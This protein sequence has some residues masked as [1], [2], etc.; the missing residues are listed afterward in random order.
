MKSYFITATGTG[1]GK[2]LIT[3]ALC[4]QLR[5]QGKAVTA[6]KPVISGYDPKDMHNDSANILKSCGITPTARLLETISPWRYAAP[7]APS[8]AADLEGNPIDLTALVQFC[9]EHTTLQSDVL[10]VEG[11]GGIMTPL[12]DHATVLDWMSALDWPV[13]VV[14]GSYL[15]S[16]SHTLAT[17][18]VLRSRGMTI[19]CVILSE[20]ADNP[21]SLADIAATLEK[22]L[23][24]SIPVLKIPRAEATEEMWRYTPVINWLCQ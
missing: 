23:P 21:A 12:S 24:K 7:L 8:M 4:W 15:G 22:F 5:Q 14:A 3:T 20:S 17:V 16:I 1:I 18:E 2:T 11:V 6:L 9:L 13:I 19:H 10:L